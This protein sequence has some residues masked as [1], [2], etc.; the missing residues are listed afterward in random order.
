MNNSLTVIFNVAFAAV[1]GT[2]TLRDALAEDFRA[3]WAN[4]SGL[5]VTAFGCVFISS[6]TTAANNAVVVAQIEVLNV[7]DMVRFVTRGIVVVRANIIGAA[8]L[9]PLSSGHFLAFLH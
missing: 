2:T 5:P 1:A 6:G 7:T 9:S 4:A 3:Y 8:D